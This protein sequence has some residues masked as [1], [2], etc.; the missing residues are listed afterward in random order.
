M[1]SA[2]LPA[3]NDGRQ[4][5]SGREWVSIAQMGGEEAQIKERVA[6]IAGEGETTLSRTFQSAWEELTLPSTQLLL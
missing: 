1:A 4:V 5:A 2:S 3:G 6:T